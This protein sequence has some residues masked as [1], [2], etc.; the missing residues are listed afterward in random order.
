MTGQASS[1]EGT[2]L[3]GRLSYKIN[4]DDTVTITGCA[5][6]VTWV[7][8]TGTIDGR[9]ITRIEKNAFSK[10]KKL[11]AVTLGSDLVEIGNAAFAN[12]A[13]KEISIPQS[14]K[15][16]GKKAF[17]KCKKLETV[18]FYEESDSTLTLDESIFNDCSE[19]LTLYCG[20]GSGIATYAW[21]QGISVQ[22]NDAYWSGLE[23]DINESE[24]P[25]TSDSDDE[26]FV[27][28]RTTYQDYVNGYKIIKGSPEGL[29]D[30]SY[31]WTETDDG[32]YFDRSGIFVTKDDYIIM[33]NCVAYEYGSNWV[34]EWEMALV[35]EVIFNTYS[36]GYSSL[37]DV[38]VYPNRFEGVQNYMYLDGF[39]SKVNSR[40]INAVNTYLSFPEY[41]D[42]G[43]TQFRGDGT[44]NYFW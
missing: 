44:W 3:Y 34:N 36:W 42:E 16:I 8:L 28:R 11:E 2:Y 24:T 37:R 32:Y 41:F 38:I 18:R 22:Q 29:E 14:V 5:D 1:E 23:T 25:E 43:Y 7:K 21:K 26:E 6:D 27:Y 10:C 40:V 12:T 19:N 39:S 33:C 30:M 17:A 9:K 35:A 31:T 13:I 20:W 15:T 4:E